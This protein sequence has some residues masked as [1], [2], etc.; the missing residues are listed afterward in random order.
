[1]WLESRRLRRDLAAARGRLGRIPQ[2]LPVGSLAP[3]FSVPDGHGGTLTLS[4]LLARGRPVALV[5]TLAGC[6]PC[7]PMLPELRR[8]Q[9]IAAD[10]LTIALVGIST[11]ERYDRAR[12]RHG[13]GLSLADAT[14]EDPALQDE[15]DELI[16]V[17]H[18]YDVH[19]SP[20]AV[21]VRPAGTIGS[22]PV[23]GRPAIEAVLRREI[24]GAVAL[25]GAPLSAIGWM[26]FRG[27]STRP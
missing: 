22:V 27:R 3:E 8:L 18:V 7:E 17:L 13:E 11:F 23:D 26:L 20:A 16:E 5:F 6:G 24:D 19:R 12:A 10:R 2:G 4:S 14:R 1:M 21:I 9:T 15:L 25:P